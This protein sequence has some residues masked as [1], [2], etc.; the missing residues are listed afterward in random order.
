MSIFFLIFAG[1]IFFSGVNCANVHDITFIN[2]SNFSRNFLD[3][4]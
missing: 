1:N 3:V 2:F 4:R